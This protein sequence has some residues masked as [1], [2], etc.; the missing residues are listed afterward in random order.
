MGVD[1][2]LCPFAFRDCVGTIN[3]AD[4]VGVDGIFRG[5][6]IDVGERGGSPNIDHRRR[7]PDDD[8]WIFDCV[9]DSGIRA[10]PSTLVL[11]SGPLREE[12]RK[13]TEGPG[14]EGGVAG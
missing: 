6:S 1:G 12:L 11:R 13:L 9:R 8:S 2:A 14:G 3:V 5:V 7:F 4:E 10:A